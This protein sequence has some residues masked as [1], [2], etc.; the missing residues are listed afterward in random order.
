M[1]LVDTGGW[2]LVICNY[3]EGGPTPP[4]NSNEDKKM[5]CPIHIRWVQTMEMSR[6]LGILPDG[7]VIHFTKCW[8]KKTEMALSTHKIQRIIIIV[9]GSF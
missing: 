7:E 6:D 3:A 1:L 9:P 5:T 2:S 8:V 4:P